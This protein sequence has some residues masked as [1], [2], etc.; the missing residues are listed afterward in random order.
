METNGIKDLIDKV[1]GKEGPLRV[2]AYWMH[3][4]MSEFISYINNAVTSLRSSFSKELSQKL[5]CLKSLTYQEFYEAHVKNKLVEGATYH[6]KDYKPVLSVR[7]T[8]WPIEKYPQEY[9]LYIIYNSRNIFRYESENGGVSFFD[10]SVFDGYVV[11]RKS[12]GGGH[13]YKIRYVTHD[14]KLDNLMYWVPDKSEWIQEMTVFV[15]LGK[16]S[17]KLDLSFAINEN[18]QINYVDKNTNETYTVSYVDTISNDVTLIDSDSRYWYGN[19][20]KY[21]LR[22][23]GSII[24]MQ[25]EVN[26]LD[27]CYDFIG[28]KSPFL[29]GLSTSNITISGYPSGY[30][31]RISLSHREA[32]DITIINSTDIEVSGSSTL[33]NTVFIDS[34]RI[35]VGDSN[36]ENT[37]FVGSRDI[38]ISSRSAVKNTVFSNS[39]N[40]TCNS[41]SNNAINNCCVLLSSYIDLINS[42]H[43]CNI[44]GCYNSKITSCIRSYINNCNWVD[45]KKVQYSNIRGSGDVDNAKVISGDNISV[46]GDKLASLLVLREGV[47]GYYADSKMNKINIPT[48][49][50]LVT[51]ESSG[52]TIDVIIQELQD[53]I[54]A[55]EGA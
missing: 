54:T 48:T 3:S 52:K 35:K 39:S 10:D 49:A 26:N 27:V 40:I 14:C 1:I 19:I 50:S 45:I 18:N 53:R 25:D 13:K 20:I 28:I 42:I 7:E 46:C 21:S 55:L 22:T 17:K 2:P 4:L 23:Y 5:D 51:D 38:N 36:V 43:D 37:K 8:R 29:S 15:H 12:H 16:E 24:R 33:I 34:Y 9:D 6:I 32:R 11:L 41:G 47:V 30:L 31:P 44:Y